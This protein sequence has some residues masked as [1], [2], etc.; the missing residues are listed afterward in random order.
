MSVHD[1]NRGKIVSKLRRELF[2][3]APAGRE[4]VVEEELRFD[5]PKEAYGPWRQR[6]SGEEIL[7]RDAPTKRYGVGVL[8]PVGASL[9][10][11]SL[12]SDSSEDEGEP[13]LSDD[14]SE[15]LALAVK[16]TEEEAEA[17]AEK[18]D[19]DLSMA[20]AYQ[21]SSL[22]VSFLTECPKGATLA[23]EVRGGR[24]ERKQVTV[25]VG[26]DKPRKRTWWLR[27]PVNLRAEFP[28]SSLVQPGSARLT[29]LA[30]NL[31]NDQSSNTEGLDLSLIHI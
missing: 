19:L 16:P 23:V 14:V 27:R 22:G 8:F 30:A 25:L 10:E 4:I 2:G 3:P 9:E 15:P 1:E 7:M 20:N 29:E 28:S 11:G 31:P 13:T 12:Q 18:D 5:D 17:E 26:Q 21:P 6:G 24:Y